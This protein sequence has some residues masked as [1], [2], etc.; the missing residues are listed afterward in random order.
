MALAV[1]A[2]LAALSGTSVVSGVGTL[3]NALISTAE[4]MVID[5][6]IIGIIRDAIGGVEV[7]EKTLANDFMADGVREGTFMTSQHTLDFLRSGKLW[8]ADIFSTEP[9]ETWI[10]ASRKRMPRWPWPSRW[11]ASDAKI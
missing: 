8:M 1:G 3:N 10:R 4:Q 5:N 2:L 6:E 9:Y 11:R 7:T